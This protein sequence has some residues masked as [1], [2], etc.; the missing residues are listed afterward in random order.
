MR[1]RLLLLDCGSKKTPSIASLL[2]ELDM[3]VDTLPLLS[4]KPGQEQ[5]YDALL[6]SGAPILLTQTDAEP[7]LECTSFLRAPLRPVLGICFGHQLMGLHHG[8]EVFRG[9][10]R[11]EPEPIELLEGHAIWEGMGKKAILPEDHTEGITLP[12]D[13]TLLGRSLHYANE[14]MC[15][16]RLPLLGV[17]FHPEVSEEYGK[18]FFKN[19]LVWAGLLPA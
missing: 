11:R 2:K 15:H 18:R 9:P 12:A 1:K 3:E 7:Y 14:A 13:F 17:Q 4:L 5:D 16:K 19:F 8:A 10:A 6:L